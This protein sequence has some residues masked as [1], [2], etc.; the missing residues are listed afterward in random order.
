LRKK[1]TLK[2]FFYIYDYNAKTSDG[3]GVLTDWQTMSMTMRRSSCLCFGGN[4]VSTS[5]PGRC[6]REN[7]TARW[8][9]SRTDMSL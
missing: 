2:R 9:F 8:W 4:S 5:Q 7:A 6:S 1:E 3:V